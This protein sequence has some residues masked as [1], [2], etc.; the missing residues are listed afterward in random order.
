MARR[1]A[2][3]K[4]NEIEIEALISRRA[5]RHD[6]AQHAAGAGGPTRCRRGLAP[7]PEAAQSIAAAAGGIGRSKTMLA[8]FCRPLCSVKLIILPRQARDRH[9]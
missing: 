2:A 3:S 6:R 5:C 4:G 1:R 8:V 7:F 9:R